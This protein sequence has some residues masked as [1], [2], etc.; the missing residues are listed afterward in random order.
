MIGNKHFKLVALATLTLSAVALGLPDHR[1][2]RPV[3]VY[4][5]AVWV[6]NM[7]TGAGETVQTGVA[8]L[9]GRCVNTGSGVW[10]LR[11][12]TILSGHGVLVTANRDEIE[13]EIGG[14]WQ[15]TVTSGTG[16]FEGITGGLNTTWQSDPVIVID[17]NTNT[18]TVSLSYT[19]DG[20][21]TY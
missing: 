11:T 20:L 17:P 2:T 19:A 4:A 12:F 9:L 16:R 7:E 13:W 1:V 8:S 21:L 15:V 18:M 6:I 5:D 10:D 3:H 14:E